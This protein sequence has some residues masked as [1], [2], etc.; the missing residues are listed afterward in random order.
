MS[1]CV[2]VAVKEREREGTKG[3][4]KVKDRANGWRE[5][6]EGR[7]GER[8]SIKV[9]ALGLKSIRSIINWIRCTIA[10][11]VNTHTQRPG[12]VRSRFAL[13]PAVSASVTPLL[14][15]SIRM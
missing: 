8:E 15:S 9:A 4:V 5:R 3:E 14:Y 7:E 2:C 12:C 11:G 1:E 10:G 6:K 13:S